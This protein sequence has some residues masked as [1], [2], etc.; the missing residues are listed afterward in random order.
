MSELDW[1]DPTTIPTTQY[2]KGPRTTPDGAPDP[3]Y[4]Q[5]NLFTLAQIG[6]LYDL[7]ALEVERQHAEV[8]AAWR[9]DSKAP[10]VVDYL[11]NRW[12]SHENERNENPN[13]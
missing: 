3:R 8:L 12:R 9:L 10:P 2:A 4:I 11:Q 5:T 13:A 1:S 6:G 7:I